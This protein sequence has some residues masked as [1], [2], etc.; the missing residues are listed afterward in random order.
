VRVVRALQHPCLRAGPTTQDVLDTATVLQ[1]REAQH[2][3]RRGL[4]ALMEGVAGDLPVRRR[5]ASADA[6]GNRRSVACPSS[7]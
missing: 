1:M 5:D 7:G 2:I 3:F 4:Q 6:V